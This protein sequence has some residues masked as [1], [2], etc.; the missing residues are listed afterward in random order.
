VE[1]IHLRVLGRAVVEREGALVT[2]RAV[3]SH[4]LALLALLAASPGRTASRERLIGWL[5]PDSES[6]R[7][8]HRLSVAL[9]A[10]RREL[11]RE[12]VLTS[13]DSV[14]LN[15]VVVW[16]DVGAF[17]DAIEAGR[18]ED[19]VRVCSGPFLDGFYL[20]DGADFERWVEAERNG[21]AGLCRSALERLAEEAQ[22]RQD[23]GSLAEWRRRLTVLAP[24]DSSL[25]LKLIDAL[26]AKG[27]AAGAIAHARAYATR[28][29]ADLGIPVNPAVL[30]RAE[31]LVESVQDRKNRSP[32][33]VES[34][35]PVIE[36]A[37]EPPSTAPPRSRRWR[38]P[39]ALAGVLAIG[40]IWLLAARGTAERGGVSSVVVFP[41][42]NLGDGQPIGDA[43]AGEIRATLSIVPNLEVRDPGSSGSGVQWRRAAR[44]LRAGSAVTGT[45]LSE[46][47]HATVTV[48]LRDVVTGETLWESTHERG[49]RSADARVEALSMAVADDLR[50]KLTPYVPH[51]YTNSASAYESFL[52]G[53]Y[54]HRKLD[55]EQMWVALQDYRRAWEE[56]PGFALAHAIAGTAYMSLSQ[57]LGLSP[58]VGWERGREHVMQAL[59]IDPTLPEGYS[60]L[61]R[62]QLWWDRDFEAAEATLRR[63]IML[64]P[65]HPDA[66]TW[67]AFYQLYYLQDFDGAI[68]NMRLSLDVDPL[69]TGRSRDI[70]TALYQSRHFEEVP[71]Q[72]R[73]T[74][75]LDPAVAR[76]IRNYVLANAY[77]EMGMYG[78]AIAEYLAVHEVRG[79][80]LPA[81][82][83][84]AYARMG[85]MDDARA[86]LRGIE[87][88]AGPGGPTGADAAALYDILGQT[89]RAFEVLDGVVQRSPPPFHLKTNPSYDALRSDPRFDRLL[90]RLGLPAD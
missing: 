60:V 23:L 88:Q 77:R 49:L 35:D 30:A 46:S 53:V 63:A 80:P 62:L 66:R 24:Y 59:E 26:A 70:E 29:E 71:A 10:I 44:S 89:D 16:T 81:G 75:S 2:G 73:H 34:V 82:L 1:S 17:L 5:W 86:V 78:E 72:H 20:K 22:A 83:G 36:P 18:L 12:A 51:H 43:L 84:I 79:G 52:A 13:G 31:H 54:E 15:P 55:A 14:A 56:D 8:R 67:Y 47:D 32:A 9:H 28:V 45:V 19:A 68:A 27:D 74:E 87:E 41:F 39:V 21:L 3:Q 76:S 85:R 25:A 11:G 61:G 37:P 6:G 65:T 42:E 57:N 64:Y 50:T 58:E 40:A 48:Q 4:H 38:E 69:N 90:E 7:A 33:P